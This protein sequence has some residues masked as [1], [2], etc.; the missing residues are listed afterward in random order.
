MP[1]VHINLDIGWYN[2]YFY[3]KPCKNEY[4]RRLKNNIIKTFLSL[5]Y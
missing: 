5:W 3:D 4:L 1:D 2:V